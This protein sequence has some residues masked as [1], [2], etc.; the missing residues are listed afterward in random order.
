MPSQ[1]LLAVLLLA[2]CASGQ[3][4][5]QR[6]ATQATHYPNLIRAELPLYPPLARAA[7]ITGT[8]VIEATV[9][10]GSVVETKVK[11]AT[12]PALSNPAIANLKTWKFE[13]EGQA[14]LVVTYVYE[15]RGKQT[16]LPQNPKVELDLPRFVKVT[17]RPF[18]PTCSGCLP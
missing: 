13:P 5:Q 9:E 10:K 7:H 18:K 15:I 3:S 4:A 14:T 16:P 17:A 12:S 8:V 1:I 11:S 6:A 2:M